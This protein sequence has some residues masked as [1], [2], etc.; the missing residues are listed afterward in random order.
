MK[1]SRKIKILKAFATAI[2][3]APIAIT[4]LALV[5]NTITP[6]NFRDK[7]PWTEG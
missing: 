7:S 4:T 3:V 5:S 6:L 2:K 1:N